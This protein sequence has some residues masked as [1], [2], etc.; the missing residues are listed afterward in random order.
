M[1][2]SEQ[3]QTKQKIFIV[4]SLIKRFDSTNKQNIEKQNQTH[5]WIRKFID[6]HL[7]ANETSYYIFGEKFK[8]SRL[9]NQRFN[10]T[11]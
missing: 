10:I 9:K 5:E 1:D 11:V 8:K 4:K 7:Q 6:D 3:K 2:E